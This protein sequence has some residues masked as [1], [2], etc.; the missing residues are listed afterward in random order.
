MTDWKPPRLAALD[1]DKLD[2]RQKEIHGAI[3]SGPRGGVRGPLAIWLHRPELAAAAQALGRYCR[4]DSLLPP[5][6]SEIAII[7][8]GAFWNS[9]YEWFAHKPI[10]LKAGVAEG[11]VES[12]RTGQ[13]P[14]FTADDERVVYSFVRATQND[15]AVP[16]GLYDEAVAILGT[17]AVVDLT[18]LI[19]YYSLIS[20]TINVFNVSPPATA[21][22][23]LARKDHLP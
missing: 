19:G 11:I 16:Q 4:Y 15:R 20:L 12:I 3:A 14:V 2:A 7:T 13:E 1:P 6:L 22:R 10:A 18:G 8:M 17:P 9:E 23:E 21:P 5:R